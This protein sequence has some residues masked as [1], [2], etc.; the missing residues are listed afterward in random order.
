MKDNKPREEGVSSTKLKRIQAEE[1]IVEI[2]SDSGEGAQT[3]GQIFG[4]INAKMGYGVWTVE[5]IPAEI[6][7]PARS[8]QGASGNRIRFGTKAMTNA[9]DT[10]DLVVA[11][12]E[13][14]L[15]SRIDQKGL[16]KGTKVFIDRK[17]ADSTQPEIREDYREALED[18]R[19]RGYEIYETP[20]EEECL[21]H[22]TD[23]R[24]GKNM[25]VVGMLCGIYS[26]D[27]DLVKK[28]IE[29]RF[30]KKGDKVV[31][32]NLALFQ[33]GYEWSRKSVDFEVEVPAREDKTV[34]VVMN[35]NQA[36]ALGCMAAGI[37]VCSMYPITPATSASHHL[38]TYFHNVGGF[39]HQA[40][41][42]IAAIGFAIGV[43]YA[44]KTPVTIT[45]GPGM[46]LKTEFIAL[47]SMAEIPLVVVDVQRGGPSTGLPTK[48]EQAD[49]LST[50]YGTHGDAPKIII[51]PST[52]EECFHF[53]IMARKLAESFR[54]PVFVLT[55]ANLAT[56]VQPFPRPELSE[57]WLSLPV[58]QSPWNPEIKPYQ[59]DPETGI[60]QR[61][62]PGQRDGMYVLT[63]L[64]HN[65][66]SHIAYDSEANQHGMTMRSKK[67]HTLQKTLK[68][69]VVHGDDKGDLLVVGWGSTRGSIEEAV[70]RLRATGKKVS[71]LHLR[72]LSPME[73]DLGD[74]F[75]KFKKVMT[76][77]INYSD[78]ANDPGWSSEQRTYAQLAMMLRARTL[79]DIDCWSRVPGYPLQ[80]S[81]V[82][83]AIA[84]V[85]EQI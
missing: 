72:F 15:Y 66:K 35:G 30:K 64:A 8:R 80:P 68:A 74:I 63:G 41:D 70:D 81:E 14:A 12:N 46:A 77:E 23:P 73:K 28:E 56:G 10:A 33:S 45:S 59:W 34:K 43:S 49:L 75:K 11:F 62:I 58:D 55:D 57:D 3:A 27:F 69:P 7:P 1:Q 84:N 32:V 38:A 44:G 40:E 25:W 22:I 52:I 51:A 24:R 6:E 18:F 2:I 76:V 42:E 29:G 13:Q 85:L 37:E 17:W 71:S 5:I 20:I 82:K 4:T 48:V 50:L 53:I 36:I 60:S 21:K 19:K 9:G 78:P 47:A 54:I 67:L 83:D 65:E 16:R 31:A 61:P 26:R 79:V 39:V